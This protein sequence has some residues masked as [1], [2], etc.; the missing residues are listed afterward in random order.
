MDLA[1]LAER[2]KIT[3]VFL[4]DWYV[5]F[6]VYDDSLDAMLKAGHQVGTS[7]LSLANLY[8]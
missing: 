5:G 1:K 4:A 3:A 8:D 2:G 6:D 7:G